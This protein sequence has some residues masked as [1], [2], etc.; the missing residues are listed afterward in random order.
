M[1][2]P[3]GNLFGKGAVNTMSRHLRLWPCAAFLSASA[4][5]VAL[6][7][8]RDGSGGRG[9]EDEPVAGEDDRIEREVAACERRREARRRIAL[10]LA[11]G[12]LTLL[13]AA[14]HFRDLN[15]AY[16]GFSWIPFRRHFPGSS[17]DER[18]CRQVIKFVA[19]EGGPGRAATARE[20]LEAQ[21]QDH[22]RRGTLRLR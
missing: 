16:P 19:L 9:S 15:E 3:A 5:L 18:H 17:D 13:E 10:D 2:N 6:L 21:L 20:R 22:L 1:N 7:L 11:A 4:L 12:R 14:E 8:G